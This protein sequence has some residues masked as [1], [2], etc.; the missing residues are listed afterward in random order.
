MSDGSLI[1]HDQTVL[2]QV[3]SHVLIPVVVV[4][5]VAD[6]DPLGEAL[7]SGGLPVAEVTL[8]TSAAEGAMSALAER[9][10]VLVGA[11]TVLTPGQAERAIAAGARFVVSPG[12]SADVVRCCQEADVP[13]LPGAVS[14]TDVMRALDL[15][16]Q[17]VKFFPAETSGGP[18]AIHALAAPFAGVSFVP[19]GG[20]GP[21]NLASYLAL[22][23]VAAVGGSWMVP[24][25]ALK[26]RDIPMLTTLVSDAVAQARSLR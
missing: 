3:L 21:A 1:E 16:V 19:T 5:D 6:V 11:G 2:S 20:I 17:T 24:S 18:A 7:V 23:C 13:V 12:L 9:R 22:E 10:D 8:R 25:A 4:R 14:A 26:A 15:G